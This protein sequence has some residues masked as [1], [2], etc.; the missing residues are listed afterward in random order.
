MNETESTAL[1]AQLAPLIQACRA[2][3]EDRNGLAAMLATPE[4]A[5][6]VAVNVREFAAQRDEFAKAARELSKTVDVLNAALRKR[7]RWGLKA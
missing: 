6:L 5:D 7:K 3:R 1:E 4:G 2:V